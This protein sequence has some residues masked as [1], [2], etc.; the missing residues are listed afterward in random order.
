MRHLKKWPHWSRTNAAL[1]LLGLALYVALFGLLC[2]AC[3]NARA[4]FITQTIVAAVSTFGL[5]WMVIDR[6]D[7]NEKE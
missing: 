7:H 6:K 2:C 1:F 3:G 5:L 4:V